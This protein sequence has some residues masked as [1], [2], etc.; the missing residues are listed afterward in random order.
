MKTRKRCWSCRRPATLVISV[1]RALASA[2][3]IATGTL[4]GTVR[5]I[6]RRDVAR[7]AFREEQ[8]D[9]CQ[10]QRGSTVIQGRY[11]NRYH[12]EH[13]LDSTDDSLEVFTRDGKTHVKS[14]QT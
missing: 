12:P 8:R 13:H 5:S 10:A 3:E 11:R 14:D 2:G 6:F 7:L 4:P 1:R 9:E